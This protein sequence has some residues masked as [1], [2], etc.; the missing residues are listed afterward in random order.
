MTPRSKLS[1]LV[2]IL[3]ALACIAAA[4]ATAPRPAPPG[5]I[6]LAPQTALTPKDMALRDQARVRSIRLPLAWFEI[7]DRRP[8]D[9]PPDWSNFEHSLTVAAEQGISVLPFA[10]GTPSWV[11]ADPTVEPVFSGRARRAWTTFLRRA[12]RR[13]GPGGTFWAQHPELPPLV[14]RRWQIWNEPNIIS[15]SRRPNPRRWAGLVKLS[16]RALHSVNPNAEILAS[17]LFGRPLQF[18]PNYPS[19]LFLRRAMR[20]T[21]LRNVID[22]I[23]L[24]PYVPRARGIPRLVTDLRKVLRDFGRP[25]MPL[26]ITEMG[27]GS[28]RFES[29]WERGLS[30]Q[31]RE[32]NTAMRLLTQSRRRWRVR[33]IY[34]YSWIDA[35]VCQFCDSAGLFTDSGEAKPAWYAFNSWTGGNSQLPEDPGLIPEIPLDGLTP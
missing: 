33:R 4:P 13:Y 34:W 11:A 6:G 28:D 8:A 7:V 35:P 16:A 23:G 9:A 27:W 1:T 5:M 10:W 25:R 31:A 2:A 21:G 22:G 17:G 12:A 30:G 32:L 29:R 15:F 19:A 24:H 18:P 26:W 20:G 14:I 3:A